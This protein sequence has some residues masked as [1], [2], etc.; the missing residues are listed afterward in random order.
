MS[1]QR[2][3][4]KRELLDAIDAIAPNGRL[5]PMLMVSWKPLV[6]NLIAAMRR[7]VQSG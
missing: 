1:L 7:Y 3:E 2:D 6:T 4:A 5:T